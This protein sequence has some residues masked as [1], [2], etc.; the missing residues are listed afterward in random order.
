MNH[1]VILGAPHFLAEMKENFRAP[2]GSVEL[3]KKNFYKEPAKE[4]TRHLGMEYVSI[5]EKIREMGYTCKILAPGPMYRNFIQDHLKTEPI[6]ID[7]TFPHPL[8]PRD[9]WTVIDGSDTIL[10]PGCVPNGVLPFAQEKKYEVSRFGEGG[11]V[12]SVGN[13]FFTTKITD[14]DNP[15][16]FTGNVES[17]DY[18][19]QLSGNKKVVLL[20]NPVVVEEIKNMVTGYMPEI[21]TDRFM[22]VIKDAR[23][24]IHVILDPKIHCGWKHPLKGPTLDSQKSLELY[25]SILKSSGIHNIH[26]PKKTFKPYGIGAMQF[27][28]GKVLVSGG[29]FCLQ[30]IYSNI[31]GKENVFVTEVPIVHYGAIFRAGIHCLINELVL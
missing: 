31:L 22:S 13:Y 28:D 17:K 16:K 2:Y 11:K 6:D 29:E 20:P 30:E 8:Y 19:P 9:G 3:F 26:V 1:T 4:V 10:V 5:L 27:H 18:L 24:E 12:F 14:G 15:L 25:K 23:G 21:H 7:N